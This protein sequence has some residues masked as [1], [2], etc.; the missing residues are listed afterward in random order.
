MARIAISITQITIILLAGGCAP[1]AAPVSGSA[2]PLDYDQVWYYYRY[3]KF[4]RFRT[5]EL[6]PLRL[7]SDDVR[8]AD[9]NVSVAYHYPDT[10]QPSDADSIAVTFEGIGTGLRSLN[11][12][13]LIVDGQHETVRT[14]V[15]STSGYPHSYTTVLATFSQP[16]FEKL[17]QA[18]SV[19]G[20]LGFIDFKLSQSQL[21]HLRRYVTKAK[22]IG[23]LTSTSRY[24]RE[25]AQ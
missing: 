23:K 16:K 22:K 2:K 11:D 20:R 24:E 9:L 12:L 5:F 6:A 7:L 10:G 13:I 17:V 1:Q 18:N 8:P 4:E 19:E 25:P 21:S 3:D 15:I 14:R